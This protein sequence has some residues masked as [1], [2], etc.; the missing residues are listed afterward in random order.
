[1][2]GSNR[3]HDSIAIFEIDETTGEVTSVGQESARGEWPRNV[4]LDS[5][6]EL[7]F[8]ENQVTD[9]ILAFRIDEHTGELTV[10]D[11]TLSVPESVCMRFL[12]SDPDETYEL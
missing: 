2:Y 9:D 10:T 12:P 8:V 5:T 4:P 11:D 6:G 7:L 1:M 3:G